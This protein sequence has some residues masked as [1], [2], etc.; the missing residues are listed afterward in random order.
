MT[1]ELPDGKHTKEEIE[2]IRKTGWSVFEDERNVETEV[3]RIVYDWLSSNVVDD[4]ELP[5]K[6]LETFMEPLK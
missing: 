4:T 3:L 5:A 6:F 2:Q 1:K